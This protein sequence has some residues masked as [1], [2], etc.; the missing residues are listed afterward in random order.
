MEIM[1]ND[2]S[3]L[4]LIVFP[5]EAVFQL[6]GT[7]KLRFRSEM[8]TERPMRGEKVTISVGIWSGGF[9][10][11]YTFSETVNGQRYLQMSEEKV[12]PELRKTDAFNEGVRL[13]TRW[14]PSH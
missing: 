12:L 2:E 5:D 14:T 4:P 13:A 11:P 1:D 7:F 10:G 8:V 3:F 9:I 6:N